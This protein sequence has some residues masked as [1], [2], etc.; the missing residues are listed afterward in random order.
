VRAAVWLLALGVGIAGG[1]LRG[2]ALLARALPER[3]S[4]LRL[5]VLGNLH[6]SPLELATA[7]GVGP[8]TKLA[9]LDLQR[10]QA[11]L[12]AHP[13]V[14]KVRVT[15]LPPD[16]LL[17]A[18][19]EREPVAVAQIGAERWLVDRSGSA[20]LPAA[21]GTALPALVGAKARDDARLAEGVAW[22]DAFAAHGIGAARGLFLV[23]A[24]SARAPAL[25]LASDA[26][27]PGA[28]VLLGTGE[29]DAKLDRLARLLAAGLPELRTTAEIDLRFGVDVILRPRPAAEPEAPDGVSAE[30]LF[31]NSNKSEG[32]G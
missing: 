13:W 1:A 9:A 29:R 19:E 10:V 32:A 23:D 15:T 12:T 26:P 25:E 11:G 31:G 27:A 24:D 22:L 30:N 17:V 3:A 2:E 5:A 7:A 14:A 18:V 4:Q 16:L 8:G 6:A 20:F 28:R 21:P